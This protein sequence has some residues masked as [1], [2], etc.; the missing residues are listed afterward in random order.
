MMSFLRLLPHLE[1]FQVLLNLIKQTKQHDL[2]PRIY[3]L[4]KITISN[5]VPS[6]QTVNATQIVHE[7]EA[8]RKNEAIGKW[9]G[10][11]IECILNFFIYWLASYIFTIF[12]FFLHLLNFYLHFFA[13]FIMISPYYQ[14]LR[15]IASQLPTYLPSCLGS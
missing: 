2:T 14:L 11:L 12:F 3:V 15:F 5:Q 1:K 6:Y 9:Q 7:E 13:G 10:S 8:P 4:H